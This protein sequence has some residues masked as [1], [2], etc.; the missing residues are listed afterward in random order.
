LLPG[1]ISRP[2]KDQ[3]ANSAIGEK[4]VGSFQRRAL[5][6][7]NQF[8]HRLTPDVALWPAWRGVK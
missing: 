6:P 1:N 8:R 4:R 2:Q 7:F 3:L 5:A